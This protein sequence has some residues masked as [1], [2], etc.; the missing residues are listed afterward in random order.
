M[1]VINGTS[2]N[3]RL[4]GTAEADS[5]FGKGGDDTINP[6]SGLG[7]YIDGGNGYDVLVVDYSTLT[8]SNSFSSDNMELII[9]TAGNGDDNFT[10][11]NSSDY[12]A[13]RDGNDTLDAGTLNDTLFGGNGNDRLFG[14]EGDDVMN[15]DNDN[16]Y[17]IGGTGNN[18]L[19][20]GAGN[21]VLATDDGNDY[22]DGGDN[23]DTLNGYGG[24]DVL[25]GGFGNDRIIGNFGN[26]TLT[27]GAGADDFQI[28]SQDA[29]NGVDTILDFNPTEGDKISFIAG[30]VA[31]I[32]QF[33][34]NSSTG[35]IS[36]DSNLFD[37]VAPVAFAVVSPNSGFNLNRDLIL[38]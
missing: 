10:F 34:Y 22:M 27:G 36:F 33:F 2:G 31:S 3:N 14:G 35:A 37:T 18:T 28:F 30:G 8:T 1:A 32:N 25:V 23:D 5:I 38:S 13:G 24:Q 4:F 15:G 6:G 9:V 19:F 11:N 16:D 12:L 21:D 20:G 17:M 26:D 7:D 29:F